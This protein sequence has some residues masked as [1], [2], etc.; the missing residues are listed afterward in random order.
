MWVC[1]GQVWLTYSV[2]HHSQIFVMAKSTGQ[3]GVVYM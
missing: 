1:T 3:G 2:C